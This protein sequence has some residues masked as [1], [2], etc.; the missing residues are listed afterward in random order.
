MLKRSTWIDVVRYF[1]PLLETKSEVAAS[2]LTILFLPFLH[3][4]PSTLWKCN[5]K[6]LEYS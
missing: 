1:P 6:L 3:L 2:I 4:A 5:A